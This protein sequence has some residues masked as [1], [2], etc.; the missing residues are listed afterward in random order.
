MAAQK[1]GDSEKKFEKEKFVQIDPGEKTHLPSRPE[2]ER[3]LVS[4]HLALMRRSPTA[5]R[6]GGKGC[7]REYKPEEENQ[8]DGG[9]G[10]ELWDPRAPRLSGDHQGS[11]VGQLWISSV[12]KSTELSWGMEILLFGVRGATEV[13]QC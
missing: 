13:P 7:D 12:P 6:K 9:Q 1:S 3:H 4:G 8:E 5:Q 10:A 2:P 11:L